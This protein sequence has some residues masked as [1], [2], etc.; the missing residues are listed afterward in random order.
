MRPLGTPHQLV[1]MVPMAVLSLP[2]AL[3][4]AI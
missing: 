2:R 4:S 1:G 3:V